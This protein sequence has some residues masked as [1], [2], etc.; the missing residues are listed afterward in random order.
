[1]RL[2]QPVAPGIV[3]VVEAPT[4]D[5]NYGSF[6]LSAVGLV[7]F[8]FAGALV[9]GL[10]AGAIF[11]ILRKRRERSA[12]ADEAVRLDLSSQA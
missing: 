10:L 12:Q 1:M 6:L 11:I 9:L 4:P 8:V 5:M 7:G 2:L 3:R